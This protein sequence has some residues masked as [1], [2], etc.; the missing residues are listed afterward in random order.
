MYQHLNEWQHL[1]NDGDVQCGSSE[2]LFLN[3]YINKNTTW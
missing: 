2:S 3:E 1:Y